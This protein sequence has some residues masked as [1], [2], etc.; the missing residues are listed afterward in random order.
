MQGVLLAGCLEPLEE[1][2]V[3]FE[4]SRVGGHVGAVRECR[5]GVEQRFA[6]V[7][8]ALEYF[9]RPVGTER[10]QVSRNAYLWDGGV[11]GTYR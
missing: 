11:V 1:A 9:V 6:Q 5:F 10:V 2:L 8:A 3:H 4:R 7:R